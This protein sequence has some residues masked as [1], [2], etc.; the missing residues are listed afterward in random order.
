MPLAFAPDH[1]K[2]TSR[3]GVDIMREGGSN[4]RY[5]PHLC[6]KSPTHSCGISQRAKGFQRS[7]Q[8]AELRCI[9]KGKHKLSQ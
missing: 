1:P 9:K 8:A 3:G 5:I 2:E 6:E 4:I 7:L